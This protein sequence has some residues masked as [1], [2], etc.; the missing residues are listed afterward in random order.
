MDEDLVA[1]VRSLHDTLSVS[2]ATN[3]ALARECAEMAALAEQEGYQ[4][5]V[6]VLRHLSRSHRVKALDHAG[7]L[8]LLEE[9]Y[10]ILLQPEA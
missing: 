10:G 4:G 2:M 1:E 6:D 3:E 9:Q 8:A 5:M 7:K